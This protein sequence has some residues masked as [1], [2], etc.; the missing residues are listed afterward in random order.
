[1]QQLSHIR[2]RI[3]K[4]RQSDEADAAELAHLDGLAIAGFGADDYIDSLVERLES[5]RSFEYGRDDREIGRA[6][7]YAGLLPSYRR[8]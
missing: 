7:A 8:Y 1:V 5:H 6:L 3:A 4:L 2:N